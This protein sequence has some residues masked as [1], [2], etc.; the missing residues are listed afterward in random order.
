MDH[1]LRIAGL[2]EFGG[3]EAGPATRP[4][5]VL[6]ARAKA[7]LPALE[8]SEH[9]EWLGHRPAT[10]DCLPVIGPTR[11]YDNIHLAFGHGH[12]GLTGGPRTG[13]LIADRIIGRTPNIDMTPYRPDRF[14]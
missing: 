1:A 13:R 2:V 12:V 7:L 6:A 11:S 8:Y 14:D 9:S 3:L 5:E 4:A 10:P